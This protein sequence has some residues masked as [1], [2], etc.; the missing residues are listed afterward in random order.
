MGKFDWPIWARKDRW[1]WKVTQ[2]WNGFLGIGLDFDLIVFSWHLRVN[3]LWFDLFDCMY[4]TKSC[5][6]E[7]FLYI[8]HEFIILLLHL[9]FSGWHWRGH[10]LPCTLLFDLAQVRGSAWALQ[11][12]AKKSRCSFL[13]PSSRIC[14]INLLF[15]SSHTESILLACR[16]RHPS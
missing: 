12:A 4:K 2:S 16:P 8:I 1:W 5:M 7:I 9:G 11:L 3:K 13:S 15:V 14:R 10:L 6:H